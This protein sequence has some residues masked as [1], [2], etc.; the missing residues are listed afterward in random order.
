MTLGFIRNI[1][2]LL[3]ISTQL[4]FA[5][6]PGCPS[7]DLGSDIS[8]DCSTSSCTDLTANAFQIGETTSYTVSSI[9]YNPPY[10]FNTGTSIFQSV[11]DVWSSLISL[12]FDFCFFGNTYNQI[13][14][15]SNGVVSFN[16]GSANGYC[17]WSFSTSIPNSSIPYPNSINGA[18]HDIDPSVSGS[19]DVNYAVLGTY[20]CRT[21]VVNYYNVPHY[22]CN[23][24]TTT[25]QIVLYETTNVIEVYIDDKPTCTSWNGG[26]AVIGIQNASG[27]I[28]YCPPN[29][30]TGPWSAN[31]EAWRFTPSGN[32]TSTINWYDASGFNIGNVFF[33]IFIF[34]MEKWYNRSKGECPYIRCQISHCTKHTCRCCHVC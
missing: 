24:L 3:I 7:I 34:I 16:V 33:H 6:A 14:I 30:N 8:L 19:H 18:Y 32:T 29:R 2:F 25:Q 21:F 23:N 5:Q 22:Q 28:G 27:S 1:F 20:P 17:A 13:I 31:Q 26:N 12:P 4:V 10:S 11:D 9:S 15:G